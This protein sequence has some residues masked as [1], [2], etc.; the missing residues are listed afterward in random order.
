[1]LLLDVH[2]SAAAKRARIFYPKFAENPKELWPVR[3]CI[4]FIHFVAF[5][6][7]CFGFIRVSCSS[8]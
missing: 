3:V 7:S 1:M 8:T 5:F 6:V 2:E 4:S